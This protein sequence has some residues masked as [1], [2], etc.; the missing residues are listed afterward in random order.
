MGW[1][2]CWIFT[3]CSTKHVYS[4]S[5]KRIYMHIPVYILWDLLIDKKYMS[6]NAIREELICHYNNGISENLVVI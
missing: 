4:I 2:Y 5:G 3:A 6:E 1:N